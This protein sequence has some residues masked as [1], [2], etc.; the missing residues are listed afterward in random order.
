MADTAQGR[1]YDFE[2]FWA[3]FFGV[4]VQK[5]SGS[6]WYAKM[7]VA[8]SQIL[9]SCKHT[10]HASFRISEPIMREVQE[11]ITGQGGIGG[12][13]IPGL[14]THTE[15]GEVFVTLRAEDFLR[16]ADSGELKYI[17]SSK[18]VAKRARSKTPA[19]LRDDE[20]G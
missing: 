2:E 5:G 20:S 18:A 1:G 12:S 19:L 16:L 3:K 13:V 6:V 14:A 9:W 7:D 15:S 10:D 11:A 17:Q 4:E 8:D